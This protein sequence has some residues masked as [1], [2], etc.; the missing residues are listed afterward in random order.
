[1]HT[2]GTG[3]GTIAK[4]HVGRLDAISSAILAA[5]RKRAQDTAIQMSQKGAHKAAADRCNLAALKLI[6]LCYEEDETGRCNVDAAGVLNQRIAVPWSKHNYQRYA[7]QRTEADVL[8][9][10][11]NRLQE[12]T[13]NPLWIYYGEIRRWGVNLIDYPDLAAAVGYWRRAGLRAKHYQLLA[14]TVRN[15][16]ARGGSGGGATGAA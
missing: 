1:M 3:N 8:K 10:H 14:Q 4:E 15:G 9:L 11:V 16:R 12:S 2:N 7:L 5:G 6:E 13:V